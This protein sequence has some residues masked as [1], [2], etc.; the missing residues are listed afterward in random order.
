MNIVESVK[1]L[2][3]KPGTYA[4]VGSG[5]LHV[6]KLRE[7]H[8]IDLIVTEEVYATLKDLGWKENLYPDNPGRPKALYNGDFDA[9]TSWSVG[10]YNPDPADLIAN[11]DVIDGVAFVKLSEVLQWKQACGR[12]KDVA[13]V[14]LIKKYLSSKTTLLLHGGRLKAVD[15][16]N[17]TYFKRLT[18]DLIDGDTILHIGFACID[19]VERQ[20]VFE[21]DRNFILKQTH[22]KLNIVHADYDNFELQLKQAKAVHITGGDD[23]ELVKTIRQFANFR[24]LIQGKVVGGSSAGACLFG[25]KYWYTEDRTIHNGL[26]ILDLGIFVHYGNEAFHGTQEDYEQFKNVVKPLETLALEECEW[27]EVQV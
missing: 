13:D 3:L 24:D 22:A 6:R 11:T 12:P 10:N 14:K 8:D 17:D 16:R 4:V 2:D 20:A 15:T 27:K 25:R 19:A 1:S 21:R 9:S 7:A 5:P 23:P 26:G 18:R